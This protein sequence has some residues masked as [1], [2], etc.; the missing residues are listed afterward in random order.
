MPR[1]ISLL[2]LFYEVI[3]SDSAAARLRN[4]VCDNQV[5]RDSA[6]GSLIDSLQVQKLMPLVESEDIPE[7]HGSIE[8]LLERISNLTLT[9]LIPIKPDVASDKVLVLGQCGCEHRDI[10]VKPEHALLNCEY[11]DRK[12]MEKLQQHT[13]ISYYRFD[14]PAFNPNIYEG[15]SLPIS[16]KGIC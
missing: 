15:K 2:R 12:N 5:C 1:L 10:L 9:T 6:L 4:G 16:T 13:A 14:G 3:A 11:R 8:L 7:W